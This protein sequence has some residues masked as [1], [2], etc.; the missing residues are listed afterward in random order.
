MPPTGWKIGAAAVPSLGGAERTRLSNPARTI[1]ESGCRVSLALAKTH[2][3]SIV[4][5]SLKNMLSSIHPADRVMMHGSKGGGNG[6]SG[7]RRL[8][9]EVLK[10]DS[11]AVNGLTRAMGPIA[12]PRYQAKKPRNMLTTAR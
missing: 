9:V 6:Y 3:T 7:W 4:T 8:A 12:S 2:V 11:W 10:G 5:L 1:A